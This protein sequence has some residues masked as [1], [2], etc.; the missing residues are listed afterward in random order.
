[1]YVLAHGQCD[2]LVKDQTKK[3]NFVREISPGMIF[4]EVGLICKIKRTA[5]IRC[6]D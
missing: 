6:K 3:E 2:V 1:M 4:G 5:S